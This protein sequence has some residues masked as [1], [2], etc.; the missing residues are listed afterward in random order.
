MLRRMAN[1]LAVAVGDGA[2]DFRRL[3]NGDAAWR[4]CGPFCHNAADGDDAA[5]TDLSSVH[6]NRSHA[7]QAIV[8]DGCSVDDRAVAERYAIA[9]CAGEARVS[10]QDAA[11]LYVCLPSDMDRFAV[12]A[13]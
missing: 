8:F 10:V 1:T 6:H 4:Y 12:A 3:S 7:N 2:L 13:N 9:Q 11:I 5:L